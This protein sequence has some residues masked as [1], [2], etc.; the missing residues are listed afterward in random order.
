[1]IFNFFKNKTSK[2]YPEFWKNYISLFEE[3]QKYKIPI[4]QADFVIIDVES[5][6]LDFKKDKILSIGGVKIKN[7]QIDVSNT[8]EIYLEQDEFNPDAA[9]VH[10]ILKKSNSEKI[11]EQ[12]GIIKFLKFIKNDI[13]V[14][15]SIYFDISIINETIK[16]NGGNKLLNKSIDTINLYKRI[17]GEDYKIDSSV[18][19]DTLS[20]EFKIT[21]SDRHNA[22]GD[23][24]ITAILFMKLISKLK[25]RGV[26]DLES[27]LKN[28]RTLF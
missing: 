15:H 23:A 19:L 8:F 26:T 7:N 1:M 21:K 3:K 2:E 14:G 6:G 11:S 12:D 25:K 27:L 9:L 16:R 4:S 24:I 22:A 10:G 28:K 18:S 17:K 20:E 13:I 5:T